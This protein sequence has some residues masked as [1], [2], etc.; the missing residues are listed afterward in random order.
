MNNTTNSW[1]GRL[2]QLPK[3]N[4]GM[5]LDE[6]ALIAIKN[7]IRTLLHDTEIAAREEIK[8]SS[9]QRCVSGEGK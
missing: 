5:R 8:R 2:E 9:N 7:F 4:P 3:E 1:E 6:N